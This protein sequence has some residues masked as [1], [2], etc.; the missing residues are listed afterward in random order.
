MNQ[1]QLLFNIDATHDDIMS[2]VINMQ[3]IRNVYMIRIKIW[4]LKFSILTFPQQ[5]DTD[6]PTKFSIICTLPISITLND[7]PMWNLI[8]TCANKRVTRTRIY[9]NLFKIYLWDKRARMFIETHGN[10]A[11]IYV[12]I[13]VFIFLYS[14]SPP[15]LPPPN[16]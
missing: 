14:S 7:R 2:H 12:L 1:N 6:Y 10:L 16:F 9:R 13:P 3:N 8:Q 15:L 4:C 11:V 5:K